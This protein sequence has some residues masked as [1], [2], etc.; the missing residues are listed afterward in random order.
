MNY[1]EP[2]KNVLPK[3]RRCRSFLILLLLSMLIGACGISAGTFVSDAEVFA[4]EQSDPVKETGTAL[5]DV[6]FADDSRYTDVKQI[7]LNFY[8]TADHMYIWSFPY[9]DDF[10]RYPSDE[11]SRLFHQSSLG[12]AISA[13]RNDETGFIPTFPQYLAEAGFTD[14]YSFGYDKPTAPNSLAGVIAHKRVD[15]TTI[16]AAAACGAGYG[17]EWSSNL[18]V[19]TG[20]RHEGFNSAAMK[21]EDHINAYIKEHNLNGK[22]KLW[23]SGYSRSSAI[24]NITAADM[25]ESGSFE[26]VYAYLTAVP[27]TTK[28][29]VAYPGV[30]NVCGKNDFVTCVPLQAW[31]FDRYGT[32]LFTPSQE[33]DSNYAALAHTT[34]KT[35]QKLTYERFRNNPELNY[36]FHLVLS[37]IGFYLPTAEDYAGQLQDNLIELWTEPDYGHVFETLATAVSRH[38]DV[39]MQQKSQRDVFVDYLSFIASQHLKAH[40]RQTEDGSWNPDDPTADNVVLEHRPMTY[41]SWLFSDNSTEDVYCGPTKTRRVVFIGDVGIDILQGKSIIASIDRNGRLSEAEDADGAG[42]DSLPDIFM[43]RE[44]K[45]TTVSIPSDNTYTIQVTAD[46]RK[47]LTYYDLSYDAYNVIDKPGMMYVGNLRKGSYKM[48]IDPNKDL[49]ELASADPGGRASFAQTPYRYSPVDEMDTEMKADRNSFLSVGE[50]IK[51]IVRT[52]LL[53]LLLFAICLM[54]YLMH[55]REAKKGHVPYSSW[56]VIIPHLIVIAVFAVLTQLC[57]YYLFAISQAMTECAAIT[58]FVIFLLSLR[59][60]IR[61]RSRRN[62]LLVIGLAAVTAVV[63][64]FYHKLPLISFSLFHL[65]LFTAIV[66]GFTVLAIRS[67]RVSLPTPDR[68]SPVGEAP[69]TEQQ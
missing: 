63:F 30:F 68:G 35:T 41:I 59:G 61:N 10:F 26:D 49:P 56:F 60:L 58:F 48:T 50:M 55:R 2:M 43:M 67:F 9:S 18:K 47:Q 54:I 29:P 12:F 38:T 65:A 5:P 4:A 19:G 64:L 34:S 42:A 53:M 7:E 28:K 33:A 25:I 22:K 24:A 39:S 13:F 66:A 62:L 40:N 37:F 46:G 8:D 69:Q 45:E 11:F 32:T 27:R 23:I 51:I 44:G 15:D 36:Q 31:G 17:K 57:T 21:L 14:T 20:V 6:Q 3:K 1:T 52:N 16:I